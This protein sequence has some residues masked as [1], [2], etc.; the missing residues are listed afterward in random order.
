MNG[1]EAA[2]IVLER[3]RREDAWAGAVLDGL[4]REGMLTS[5][6]SALAMQLSLGVLQNESLLDHTL[7]QFYAGKLEPKL[8]DLLRLG[9]YQILFMDKIPDRAAVSE[10]VA[11]SR[12]NG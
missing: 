8:F 3:C 10:C 6:E 5:R 11:L 7:R 4:I 9:A 12:R 1:R 2:L